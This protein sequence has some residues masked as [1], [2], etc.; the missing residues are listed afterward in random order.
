M[1]IFSLF[2]DISLQKSQQ[3]V[4]QIFATKSKMFLNPYIE[5]ATI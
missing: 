4:L 5:I 2:T 3:P 1:Q